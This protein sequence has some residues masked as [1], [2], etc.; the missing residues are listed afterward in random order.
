MQF[1]PAQFVEYDAHANLAKLGVGPGKTFDFWDLSLKSKLEI[2]LGIRAGDRKI[3]RAIADAGVVVN[4]WHIAPYF[5]DSTFYNGNWL[6][7]AAA[8]KTD[9]HG[10]D[11]AEAISL[12]A[13]VDE[14]GKT[15]DGSKHDYTLSFAPDRLPPVNAFWSLTMYNGLSRLLIKNPIN[16]YLINSSMLPR[17]KRD[18]NGGLTIYIQHKFPGFDREVNWLPAPI[19]PILLVLRLYWPKA[20][21]PSILPVG[22]GTWRPPRVKTVSIERRE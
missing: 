10:D 13:Q 9:F 5:G 21:P 4:G 17:L 18:A 12:F 11:P 2:T 1:A 19:G 16:R 7:R 22:A 8:A 14:G 3:D 20:E 6:L 15:L